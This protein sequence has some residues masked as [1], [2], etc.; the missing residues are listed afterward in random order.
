MEKVF[1]LYHQSQEASN[2]NQDSLARE[3]VDYTSKT[4]INS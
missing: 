3:I 1:E 2:I 4:I